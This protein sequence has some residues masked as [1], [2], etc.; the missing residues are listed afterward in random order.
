[1]EFLS[2]SKKTAEN[3]QALKCVIMEISRLKT[4]GNSLRAIAALWASAQPIV[5]CSTA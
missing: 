5:Y 3:I 1:M 4:K 2:K